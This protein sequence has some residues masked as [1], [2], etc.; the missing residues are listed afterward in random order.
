MIFG[1]IFV[2]HLHQLYFDC[3]FS[4]IWSS[5]LYISICFI[6]FHRV[7]IHK[8]PIGTETNTFNRVTRGIE[9][10]DNFLDEVFSFDLYHSTA[11]QIFGFYCCNGEWKKNKGSPLPYT[12]NCTY[13][14]TVVYL[15]IWILVLCYISL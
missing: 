2:I 5:Y 14:N 3:I 1:A 7:S 12:V 11:S 6:C 4:F 10:F 8:I 9:L 13:I 15:Y